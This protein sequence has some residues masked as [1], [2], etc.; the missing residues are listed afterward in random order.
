MNQIIMIRKENKLHKKFFKLQFII[1]VL[2]LIF[3]G[4][5]CAKKWKDEQE[6]Q[7]VSQVVNQA[8][9]LETVYQTQRT[10]KA[11]QI[12]QNRYFG[13]IIIP[14]INLDYSVFNECNDELLKILP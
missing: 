9:E 11:Q 12:N 2:V 3:L 10:T 13:K 14:K 7:K 1:S 6:I 8:F 4:L 5:Y